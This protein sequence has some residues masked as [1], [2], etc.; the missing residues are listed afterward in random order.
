MTNTLYKSLDGNAAYA[1]RT[2]LFEHVKTSGREDITHKDV[3]EFSKNG[4]L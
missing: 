3:D 4:G 2:K 1:G